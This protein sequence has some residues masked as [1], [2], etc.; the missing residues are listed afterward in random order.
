[1]KKPSMHTSIKRVS[2]VLLILAVLATSVFASPLKGTKGLGDAKVYDSNYKAITSPTEV[3]DGYV[4]RTKT[5]AVVLDNDDTHVE[6]DSDSLVVFTNVEDGALQIYI[7]DGKMFVSSSSGDFTVMTTVTTY[8]A[9][10]G[11]SIYVIT[12][13]VEEVAFVGDGSVEAQNFILGTST[14]VDSGKY[15]D[16]SITDFSPIQGA[17]ASIVPSEIKETVEEPEPEERQPEEPVKAVEASPLTRTFVYGNIKVNITAYQG[18]AELSYPT[19]ITDEEIHTAAA[20][21]AAAYPQYMDGIYYQIAG[22]GKIVLYYPENYGEG[23]LNLAMNLIN[24]ELPAYIASLATPAPTMVAS[25][26]VEPVAEPESTEP[27][28]QQHEV[29]TETAQ[30]QPEKTPLETVPRPEPQQPEPEKK[31]DFSFGVWA[32]GVYGSGKDGDKFVLFPYSDGFLGSFWKDYRFFLR[33]YIKYKNFTFGLNAEAAFVDNEYQ[34]DFFTFNT[35]GGVLGYINSVA[36]FI[37][38]IG[39][40]GEAFK[41]LF[42]LKSDLAFQ[43]PVIKSSDRLYTQSG[44][45]LGQ[46]KLKTGVFTLDAFIDDLKLT[47]MINDGCQFA[48][49]RAGFT[50]GA[51]DMGL[52]VTAD[53]NKAIEKSLLYPAVDISVPFKVAD[54]SVKLSA[55]GAAQI[56]FADGFKL[57]GY[58][59]KAM[60]DI[61]YGALNIGFGASYNKDRHFTEQVTNTPVSTVVFKEGTALDLFGRIGIDTKVFSFK[62]SFNVPF[63]MEN[64]GGFRNTVKTRSGSLID[65]TTDVFDLQMD[66]RLGAFTFTVGSSIYGFTGKIADLV[67]SVSDD[68]QRSAALEALFTPESSKLFTRLDFNTPVGPGDLDVYIRADLDYIVGQLRIPFSI[69]ASY[70]F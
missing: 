48:G 31:S 63:D 62:T 58:M 5:D 26:S 68:E 7:L 38:V 33:P 2:A 12:D 14:S 60:L 30:T 23:E 27:E 66:L 65:L 55:Q 46:I 36:K 16:N 44:N 47:S 11:S 49:L 61:G 64:G 21:A 52:G 45:L 34:N 28:Q 35:E 59:G 6:I 13:E 37:S 20:A 50:F 10:K 29:E 42:D 4:I 25:T 57:N 17:F 43:N 3:S 39:Y 56:D 22:P 19:F 69:G 9:K 53:V 40:D 24:A 54:T 32:G 15:I 51:L 67:G 18:F 1:M 8:N 70:A 41:V